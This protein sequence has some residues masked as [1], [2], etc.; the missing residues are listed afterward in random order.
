MAKITDGY[1]EP[2]MQLHLAEYQ[3]IT[4]RITNWITLQFS[5]A[6]IIGGVLVLLADAR[7]LFPLVVNIWV[8]ATIVNIGIAAYL[9]T[10]FEMMNNA[11]YIECKLTSIIGLEHVPYW[12]YEHFRS[13]NHAYSP[14]G[15]YLTAVIA[16]LVPLIAL[17][18]H[19]FLWPPLLWWGDSIGVFICTCIAVWGFILA[20]KGSQAQRE[21]WEC[22]KHRN[23]RLSAV[24]ELSSAN[25][26]HA[27]DS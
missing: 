5:I 15:I 2:I 24:E 9:Y 22:A 14:A 7:D 1:D 3:T 26:E 16:V 17:L 6:P 25:P 27:G 8:V 12:Q 19:Y 23:T 10:L 18:L 21:L 4:A 11:Q 20:R 13:S